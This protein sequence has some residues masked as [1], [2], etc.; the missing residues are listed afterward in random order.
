MTEMPRQQIKYIFSLTTQLNK[1]YLS[2]IGF[3]TYLL[4]IIKYG[5]IYKHFTKS[6]G[7]KMFS[8]VQFLIPLNQ[9]IQKQDKTMYCL[10]DN[11]D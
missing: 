7:I 5:C 10:S 2:Q 6:T 9:N 11:S 1:L 4:I 3:Y 8:L